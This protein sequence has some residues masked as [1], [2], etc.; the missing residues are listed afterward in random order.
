MNGKGNVRTRPTKNRET[1]TVKRGYKLQT[2]MLKK[3]IKN[4]ADMSI[5]GTVTLDF[6]SKLPLLRIGFKNHKEKDVFTSLPK[7]KLEQAQKDTHGVIFLYRS[8]DD[9]VSIPVQSLF[10]QITDSLSNTRD[11]SRIKYDEAEAILKE[12]YPVEVFEY[13][14]SR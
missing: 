6:S 10:T 7:S 12:N 3:G 11:R 9:T 8:G 14:L 2:A 5:Q 1:N 13:G 4:I